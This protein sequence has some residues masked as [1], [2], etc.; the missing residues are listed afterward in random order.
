MPLACESIP[1]TRTHTH[2]DN[3]KVARDAPPEV[4]R[5]AYRTLT[6]KYHPDHNPDNPDAMRIIQVINAAYD[7]LSNPAKRVEHDKWIVMIEAQNIA[8]AS[9]AHSDVSSRHTHHRSAT[10]NPQRK[11]PFDIRAKKNKTAAKTLRA[12]HKL[13]LMVGHFSKYLSRKV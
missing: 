8:A 3:L 2:Y 6:K 5:A 1:M 4:I 11:T 7:V 12:V 9:T 10:G 13:W